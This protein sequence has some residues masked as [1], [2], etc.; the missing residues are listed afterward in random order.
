MT[1]RREVLGGLVGGAA[2]AVAAALTVD[3]AVDEKRAAREGVRHIPDR[4]SSRPSDP[5]Y[6]RPH[7]KTVRVFLDGRKVERCFE[8]D[9]KA[10]YVLVYLEKGNGAMRYEGL[11]EFRF[12]EV[13]S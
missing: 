5:D 4:L 12:P 13:P 7:Y 9:R 10:G 2:L 1:T 8:A 11:V 3:N 6:Y